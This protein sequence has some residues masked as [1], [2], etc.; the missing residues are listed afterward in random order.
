ML[1]KFG[2]RWK[3][4]ILFTLRTDLLSGFLLYVLPRFFI[5]LCIY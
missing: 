5:Y 1:D 3:E 4:H 2:R